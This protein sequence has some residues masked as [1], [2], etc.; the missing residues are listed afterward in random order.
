MLL[1]HCKEQN[2]QP[3]EKE[4]L[5]SAFKKDQQPSTPV[6]CDCFPAGAQHKGIQPASSEYKYG[7]GGLGPLGKTLPFPG[8][9]PTGFAELRLG[10]ELGGEGKNVK[11]KRFRVFFRAKSITQPFQHRFPSRG[12][13]AVF[14]PLNP[15]RG[16]LLG[17][18]PRIR[19]P[20]KIIL[21][22]VIGFYRYELCVR[23]V[24]PISSMGT[25]EFLG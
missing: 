1:S 13:Q 10:F 23:Q 16:C 14:I 4:N 8:Q 17:Q 12:W 22:F 6:L 18:V 5:C 11:F 19:N 3:A 15:A 24:S 20:F 21:G 7:A 25:E 2:H 9:S